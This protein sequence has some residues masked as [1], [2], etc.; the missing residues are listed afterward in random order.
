M[1]PGGDVLVELL[2]EGR[3]DAD[4]DGGTGAMTIVAVRR[5]MLSSDSSSV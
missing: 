4:A 1:R 2:M 5:D 3:E